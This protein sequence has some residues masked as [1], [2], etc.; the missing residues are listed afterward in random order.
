M[1]WFAC[2]KSHLATE[3]L[4]RQILDMCQLGPPYPAAGDGVSVGVL[5]CRIG[6]TSTCSNNAWHI[7][8]GV[9][10][11]HSQLIPMPF[12][13]SWSQDLLTALQSLPSV[14]HQ[15]WGVISFPSALTPAHPACMKLLGFGFWFLGSPLP[16]SSYTQHCSLIGQHHQAPGYMPSCSP[17]SVLSPCS[18][19]HIAQCSSW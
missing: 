14:Y 12:G 11:P 13:K 3:L 16:L 18:V 2:N 1:L 10:P 19:T 15:F 4:D 6:L 8:A 7:P 5:L 17:D 9:R